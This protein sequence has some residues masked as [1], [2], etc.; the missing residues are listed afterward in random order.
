M[1]LDIRIS[2]RDRYCNPADCPLRRVI[3]LGQAQQVAV[4]G[5]STQDLQALTIEQG[6][7]PANDFYGRAVSPDLRTN[8]SA[9][10][11][12]ADCTNGSIEG[13]NYIN[14]ES[15]LASIEGED[16]PLERV[17]RLM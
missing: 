5:V 11:Y 10:I 12:A 16:V 13:S 8:L 7:T 15:I 2:F 1:E 17:E 6:L 14:C 3:V 4:E 9:V